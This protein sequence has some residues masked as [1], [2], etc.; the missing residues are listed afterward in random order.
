MENILK[1]NSTSLVT[2][3]SIGAQALTTPSPD[4]HSNATSV[5]HLTIEDG[6]VYIEDGKLY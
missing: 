6:D 5:V 4:D 2:C 3:I 1:S